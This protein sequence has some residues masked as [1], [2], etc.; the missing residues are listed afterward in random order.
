MICEDCGIEFTSARYKERK[1]PNKC[2]SCTGKFTCTKSKTYGERSNGSRSKLYTSW[3][4]MRDRC[5]TKLNRDYK[6]G[7]GICEAWMDFNVYKAWA[8]ENGY[9]DGSQIRRINVK[10]GYSPLNCKVIKRK[11]NKYLYKGEMRF[12]YEIYDIIGELPISKIAFTRRLR[13]GYPINKA[14]MEPPKSNQFVY[15]QNLKK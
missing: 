13:K 3:T 12:A 11:L 8:L 7:V 5:L 1:Y 2:R 4:G 15:K 10:Q 6:E 14:I 9:C